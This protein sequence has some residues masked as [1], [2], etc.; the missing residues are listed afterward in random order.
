[1]VSPWSPCRQVTLT[2][3]R[4]PLSPHCNPPSA[5]YG[6]SRCFP[7]QSHQFFSL[8]C[9]CGF[10]RISHEI[11]GRQTCARSSSFL[12]SHAR[13][14]TL[15]A[16][17]LHRLTGLILFRTQSPLVH[18]IRRLSHKNRSPRKPGRGSHAIENRPKSLTPSTHPKLGVTSKHQGLHRYALQRIF[19]PSL[20][21]VGSD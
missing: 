8:F 16:A 10:K 20:R 9:R 14:A 3:A 18:K 2:D 17:R 7:Q 15:Y 5:P 1:M 6:Q 21:T 12:H 11:C 4:L 19:R 13:Q